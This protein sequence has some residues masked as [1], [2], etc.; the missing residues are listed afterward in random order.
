VR[1][2]LRQELFASTQDTAKVAALGE[3]LA[4]LQQQVRAIGLKAST[5]AAA[6]LTPEQREKLRAL[7]EGRRGGPGRGRAPAS[8]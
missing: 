6:V 8:V 4:T 5:A 2:S 1:L 3:Q 7:P